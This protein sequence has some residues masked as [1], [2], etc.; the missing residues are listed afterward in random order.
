MENKNFD[1]QELIEKAT[2]KQVIVEYRF[3]KSPFVR[4]M[5]SITYICPVC[6]SVLL[7]TNDEY[8]LNRLEE[9]NYNYCHKCGQKLKFD[10]TTGIFHF[11]NNHK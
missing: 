7:H 11:G 6:D 1:M 10:K 9:E 4:E 3:V 5:N 8:W 2:P